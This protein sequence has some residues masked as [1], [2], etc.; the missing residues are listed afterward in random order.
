M[1][2]T[3]YTCLLLAL[4]TGAAAQNLNPTVEVTSTYKREASGIEKPGQLLPLPDSVMRFNYDFDYAVKSTPYRGAYEF[5]PYNVLLRPSPRPEAEGTL[6]AKLGL[7][8]T[9]HPEAELVWTPL[10]SDNFHINLYGNY[11]AYMGY[12]RDIQY[13]ATAGSFLYTGSTSA[14]SWRRRNASVGTNLRFDWSSGSLFADVSYNAIA[15]RDAWADV[16]NH[17]AT[18][19]ASAGGRLGTSFLYQ[20][21][22]Y[23]NFTGNTPLTNLHNLTEAAMAIPFKA[24]TGRLD[25]RAETLNFNNGTL[26]GFAGVFGITPKYILDLGKFHLDAGVMV[27]F[28][29]RSNAALCPSA[30]AVVTPQVKASFAVIDDIFLLQAYAT[31]GNRIIAY[32]TLLADNPFLGSYAFTPDIT[33]ETLNIGIGAR[34]NVRERLNYNLRGGFKHLSNPP[35]WGYSTAGAG[36]TPVAGYMCPINTFY[37]TLDAGWKSDHID[38]DGSV[39]YQYILPFTVADASQNTLFGPPAVEGKLKAMYSFMGGRF[40]AGVTVKGMSERSSV[41]AKLPGFV[42]LGLNG[43]FAVTRYLAAWINVCNILNQTV[44][45]V[46]LYAEKGV[47]FTVGA[48]LN[49]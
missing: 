40:K 45:I 49:F 24:G 47:Y 30:P 12:Y 37:A 8:Y 3:L 46:P 36:Y 27:S 25:L 20:V 44:Q 22:E 11:N 5:K 19:N 33:V 18:V 17:G 7:G 32:D 13:D 10:R 2:K 9:F 26:S 39:T 15:G 34:G 6:F 38:I 14:A 43:E 21:T 48:R 41:N 16:Q 42:D 1:K 28:T 35:L 31:G 29:A 4:A 23:F